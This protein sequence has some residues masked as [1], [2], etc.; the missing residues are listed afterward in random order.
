MKSLFYIFSLLLLTMVGCAAYWSMEPQLEARS[1]TTQGCNKKHPCLSTTGDT[2]TTTGST[3]TT[4]TTTTT[5][6]STTG[7]TTGTTPVPVNATIDTPAA[8]ASIIVGQS[9]ALAGTCAGGTAPYTYSW[10]FESGSGIS[11]ITSEDPGATTF[12]TAGTWTVTLNCTDSLAESDLSPATQEIT[13]TAPTVGCGD[14]GGNA[15]CGRAATG[16]DAYATEGG[17]QATF[18]AGATALTDCN[19]GLTSNAKYYLLNDVTAAGGDANT[20]FNLT[21]A[22]KLDLNGH[23]VNGRIN[24]NGTFEGAHLFNGI[25][26]CTWT[27]SGGD[28]GCIRLTSTVT[29]TATVEI[30][31]IDCTNLQVGANNVRCIHVERTSTLND[32][33]LTVLKVYNVTAEVLANTSSRT[34]AISFLGNQRTPFEA[35]YNYVKCGATSNAC[36]G[37]LLFNGI[38]RI[39][40]NRVT[41]PL[42][43]TAT[44]GRCITIDANAVPATD[45]GVEVD[46]N[47]LDCVNNRF[48]RV[49]SRIVRAHD[50][51][52]LGAATVSDGA[53]HMYDQSQ[54]ASEVYTG[55]TF[56]NERFINPVSGVMFYGVAGSG[57]RISNTIVL[58][59]VVGKLVQMRTN[60]TTGPTSAT[61]CNNATFSATANLKATTISGGSSVI[62][63]FNSGIADPANTGTVT[64]VTACPF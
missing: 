37:I 20:C 15:Y 8:P 42:T 22:T 28:T 13:V 11:E 2:T 47:L 39:H 54:S 40:H 43:A 19:T 63:A 31:H 26:R 44:L 24:R 46:H 38:G 27:E 34:S 21:V 35:Y 61:V 4:G 60:S 48:L 10:T 30:H 57:A 12:S 52:Y 9:V 49:R 45:A 33:L 18:Q 17:D 5:T 53:V 25:V 55:L 59:T 6:G 3:T 64:Q 14:Y 32:T 41:Q 7:S 51:N 56:T 36:Q 29:P 58:G 1:R 50:N 62:T 16:T 23:T